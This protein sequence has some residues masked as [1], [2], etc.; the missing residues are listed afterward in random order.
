MQK[1]L[2]AKLFSLAY[3]H[4]HSSNMHMGCPVIQ[5][6]I[7]K[8]AVN[9]E[10]KGALRGGEDV[11]PKNILLI[12]L[13]DRTS[14]KEYSRCNVLEELQAHPDF[15]NVLA[16]AT[17][18]KNTDFY[19]QNG[20][21]E[22]DNK[23]ES[24]FNHLKEHFGDENSGYYFPSPLQPVLSQEFLEGMMHAIHRV[25]FSSKNML[26]RDHRLD[27]IEL[28]DV[29]LILKIIEAAQSDSFCLLCKDGVDCSAA[30]NAA[31]FCF[32]KIVNSSEALTREDEML[33]N[34]ILY[35]PSM[36]ARERVIHQDRFSRFV[37][38]L[39][40]LE[41]V[42]KEYGSEKFYKVFHD[43]FSPFFSSSILKA[44]LA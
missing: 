33:L 31:L 30:E 35:L 29:L 22:A 10:F 16:V 15:K 7:N 4:Y 18:A 3:D 11:D 21:Y 42:K 24:F 40:L 2:Q 32:L 8:V 6:S 41:T 17:L 36:C 12:N 37:G 44:R 26:L 38:M 14:W 25:F 39:K 28:F 9:D 1:T 5:E 27:F 34:R 13:Q 23:A 20:V 19:W 43:A